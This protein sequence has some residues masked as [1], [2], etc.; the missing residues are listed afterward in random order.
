MSDTDVIARR[1]RVRRRLPLYRVGRTVIVPVFKVLSA[2]GVEGRENVPTSGPVI[3]ADPQKLPRHPIYG[4]RDAARSP[5]H[6]E[7][8]IMG[9]QI[10]GMVLYSNGLVSGQAGSRGPQCASYRPMCPRRR[11]G[12]RDISGR[13]SQRRAA[14]RGFSWGMCTW[15]NEQVHP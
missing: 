11:S 12:A 8:R 13:G 10:L 6:G 5:F 3:L 14:A 15:L 9:P 4:I 7:S 2:Y 1:Y